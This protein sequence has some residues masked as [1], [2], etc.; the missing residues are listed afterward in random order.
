MCNE[1]EERIPT[2]C[3]NPG[4]CDTVQCVHCTVRIP[5]ECEQTQNTSTADCD[6]VPVSSI[7]TRTPFLVAGRRIKSKFMLSKVGGGRFILES[8]MERGGGEGA[9]LNDVVSPDDRNTGLANLGN[10]SLSNKGKHNNIKNPHTNSDI[11][12]TPKRKK[13]ST[14][15][16]LVSVFSGAN[17]T[18]PG[19]SP[20][21]R[22]RVRGQGGQGH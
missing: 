12:R 1:D 2:A 22:M 19:E 11:S 5:A 17:N 13:A 18:Q 16:E 6:N 10:F 8:N 21:K 7:E 20:A 15:S 4:L 9:F 3:V 14:V